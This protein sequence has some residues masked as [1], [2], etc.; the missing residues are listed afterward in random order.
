M[1]IT[2]KESVNCLISS[3][4]ADVQQ[5]ALSGIE[6]RCIYKWLVKKD[7]VN[8]TLI[9]HFKV[10]EALNQFKNNNVIEIDVSDLQKPTIKTY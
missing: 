3:V 1:Y 4:D 8:T 6:N 7:E 5:F 10:V 9:K 2:L